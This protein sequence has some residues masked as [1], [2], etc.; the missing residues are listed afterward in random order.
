MIQKTCIVF[1]K[2][3]YRKSSEILNGNI[4]KK[5]CV[6]CMV[7]RTRAWAGEGGRLA[8]FLLFKPYVTVT[9]YINTIMHVY[10]ALTWVRIV[11][12]KL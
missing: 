11:L 5:F 8:V 12:K 9:C 10:V 4:E 2:Y 6:R 3:R 7:W 1:S